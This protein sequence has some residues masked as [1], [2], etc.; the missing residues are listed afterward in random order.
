MS[1]K[2]NTKYIE[3]I[4]E[5]NTEHTE[6]FGYYNYDVMSHD[7]TKLLC[8][9]ADFEGRAIVASD[10]VQLGYYDIITGQWHSIGTSDSFNWQQG[11]MLQWIPGDKNLD[12]VAYNFSDKKK[13]YSK[14]VNIQTGEERILDFPI[15]CIT[16]DGKY[17][18]S[19]QYERSRWCRAYHYESVSNPEYDGRVAEHDGV[20]RLDLESNAVEKIVSIQDVIRLD[21]RGDF[22]QAKHWLEH[23]MINPSGTEF[24][25]LHRFSFGGGYETRIIVA[26][27]DG[28]NLQVI[29]GW[30]TNDWSHFGWRGDDAFV[31]YSVSKN[32]LQ[33][34]YTKSVSKSKNTRS[35]VQYIKR[36]TNTWPLKYLKKV[37]R[38]Q[39]KHY[40]S[41]KKINGTYIFEGNLNCKL[42]DIDGHPS[43]TVDG[44]Y[45]ITDSYP[46]S[47]G[48]RRLI[49]FN[50][51]TQ[52]GVIVGEFQ[53][54]LMGSP[55]SCDL[56]PKLSYRGN[57]IVV[58]TAYTGKHRMI[59]FKINWDKIHEDLA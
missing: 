26:Q 28:S 40:K 17:S 4:F 25:F 54:L 49:V 57:Y 22:D 32:A 42:F 45:M 7:G 2:I 44:R 47:H 50:R 36:A 15:Y 55:A 59:A 16:P 34:S 56:H 11:A 3:P 52:K 43:H 38:P 35:L 8:N 33:A 23:I 18:I 39:R 19:L 37:L 27:I 21:A 30:K 51:E 5:T 48:N 46:D 9:R 31:I 29:S 13:F 41:Y 20:F 14:I 53:A 12:L 1:K 6:W 10:T 58:D 24:V